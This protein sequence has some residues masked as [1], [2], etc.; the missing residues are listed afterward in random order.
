MDIESQ[1]RL[2]RLD[3]KLNGVCASVETGFATIRK[4]IHYLNRNTMPTLA[5][6]FVALV[7]GICSLFIALENR[8]LILS[9]SSQTA[10]NTRDLENA[11]P[12]IF[13]QTTPDSK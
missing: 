1:Q 12:V 2:Q 9:V 8:N 11:L 6:A 3:E 4:D 13:Q 7:L 10:K 5:V